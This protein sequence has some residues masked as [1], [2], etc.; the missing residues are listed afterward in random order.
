MTSE[1]L[2]RIKERAEVLNATC[3]AMAKTIREVE[4]HLTRSG[5]GCPSFVKGSGF[6]IGWDRMG[7]NFRIYIS[8]GAS[9][10]PWGDSPRNFKIESF[11]LLPKLL[12]EIVKNLDTSIAK[13]T[14]ALHGEP[15]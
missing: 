11:P 14:A 3:E 12:A 8:T 13:A 4:E 7:S 6:E 15:K 9:S 2:K 10:S 1:L 5:V